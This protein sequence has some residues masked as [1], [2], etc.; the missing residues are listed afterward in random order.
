LLIRD[1]RPDD[2]AHWRPLWDAYCAFYATAVPEDVTAG[3]W[4][5]ILSPQ[6]PVFARIAELDGKVAGFAICVV[7]EATWTLAPICYLEDLFVAE[8]AR[9]HGLGRAL[10]Q[11]VLA[12]AC[13]RGWSR[14]YWLTNVSNQAA[15]RLY[16]EFAQADDFVRYR[17]IL[18]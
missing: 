14:L 11:D 15:R 9:G 5:R 10:I 13:A 2:E 17:M 16:D 1:P 3:T 12:L 8:Y 4:A 6:S 7:H 18:S